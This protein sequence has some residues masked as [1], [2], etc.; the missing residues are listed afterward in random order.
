MPRPYIS[1]KS[2]S[3]KA[4]TIVSPF[5]I[6][7]NHG[8][9]TGSLI[10]H[11]DFWKL[12]SN[13]AAKLPIAIVSEVP[14]VHEFNYITAG[15]L[16]YT[17]G[18]TV[19]SSLY[20]DSNG[21]LTETNSGTNIL[22]GVANTVTTILVSLNQVH[23]LEKMFTVL[24]SKGDLIRGVANSTNTGSQI[25]ILKVNPSDG[26]FMSIE[27]DELTWA[28]PMYNRE[29]IADVSAG[30]SSNELVIRLTEPITSLYAIVNV[31]EELPA[32]GLSINT[33]SAAAASEYVFE[34]FNTTGFDVTLG[35]TNLQTTSAIRSTGIW[36]PSD[37]YVAI[38]GPDGG[39]A[40]LTSTGT[41]NE[42][43]EIV[44]RFTSTSLTAP[45]LHY[46]RYSP[47]LQLS[48][49]SSFNV[50]SGLAYTNNIYI[51]Q[52]TALLDF[53]PVFTQPGASTLM[54]AIGLIPTSSTDTEYWYSVAS[55]DI[56]DTPRVIMQRVGG[57]NYQ[58]NTNVTFSSS[59]LIDTAAVADLSA[60]LRE[61]MTYSNN[62]STGTQ[63]ANVLRNIM[64]SITGM[65]RLRIAVLM[66]S[67]GTDT[68]TVSDIGVTYNSK[69]MWQRTNT[70]EVEIMDPS[71]IVVR[72]AGIAR[73]IRVVVSK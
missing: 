48:G 47:S 73:N 36:A 68:P 17:H 1:N 67:T 70:R 59:T 49:Q 31:F 19:G 69:S 57:G 16:T 29:P 12:A 14:S 3:V 45:A 27:N 23:G 25:G 15:I 50:Q 39:V 4:K 64:P 11:S 51:S 5:V 71:T 52:W 37:L 28:R 26:Y 9:S 72:N 63:L 66:E 13:T 2:N 20:C 18:L 44:S 7:P 55:S 30:Q 21:A 46:M 10:Y 54:F 32:A 33:W 56:S 35:D 41:A 22:V 34:D 65:D 58:L 8:L 53:D 43:V 42:T 40:I 60:S 38:K 62:R 6:Q 24:Q 61:A